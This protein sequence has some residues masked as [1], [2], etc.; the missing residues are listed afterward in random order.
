MNAVTRGICPFAGAMI[1]AATADIEKVIGQT[2]EDI[3]TA[4]NVIAAWVISTACDQ[5]RYAAAWIEKRGNCPVFLFNVPSTWQTDTSR[6]LYAEEIRRLGRYLVALGGTPPTSEQL[7]HV[8]LAYEQSRQAF[9]EAQPKQSARQ[10]A[11]ALAELRGPSQRLPDPARI[12]IPHN[13]PLNAASNAIPD[14]ILGAMPTAAVGM[15]SRENND[16][17]TL[18]GHG[19]RYTGDTI[20]LAIVGGPL[21]ENDNALFE[22]VEQIGGRIALDASESGW[23]MMPRCFD[24]RQM[25]RAYFE[26]NPD[27]FRRPNTP[28]YEWLGRELAARQ[29]RGILFRR[30]VWCDLWHAELQRFKEW[31]SLP[32]LEM[33]VG[34][35]DTNSVSNRLQGRLEAFMEMLS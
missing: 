18:R 27:V 9:Y 3:T 10:S 17:A 24:R 15:F 19:A 26:G 28:L 16:M 1:D 11:D 14:A 20:P 13:R 12:A 8:M 32:V 7:S 2:V 35:D 6:N 4:D 34:I 5:M 22:M 33:D 23:R 21:L 31:T 30:Y 25:A 29:I